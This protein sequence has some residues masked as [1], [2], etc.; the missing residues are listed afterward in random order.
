[1][2]CIQPHTQGITRA[3]CLICTLVTWDTTVQRTLTS[4]CSSC[5]TKSLYE[6]SAFMKSPSFCGPATSSVAGLPRA[7]SAHA[8][9]AL[10]MP[11]HV[12]NATRVS[13][14][15]DRRVFR[16]CAHT[17]RRDASNAWQSRHVS[18]VECPWWWVP[19]DT[20][21]Q[22]RLLVHQSD[23][24]ASN[25]KL[26][27]DRAGSPKRHIWLRRVRKQ[28]APEHLHSTGQSPLRS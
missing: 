21:A 4:N 11:P 17:A 20:W 14:R 10:G 27:C 7:A 28:A 23:S 25:L 22:H 3:L 6:A 16:T 19:A 5:R 24:V 26:Q 18:D 15:A 13:S 12:S 9:T 1:M 2:T 8:R